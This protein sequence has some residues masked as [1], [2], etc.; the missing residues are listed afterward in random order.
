MCSPGVI[1]P[2]DLQAVSERRILS[3]RERSLD[4]AL[5]GTASVRLVACYRES[6]LRI[7]FSDAKVTFHFHWT[8]RG[9]PSKDEFSSHLA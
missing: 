7:C 2:L 4:L 6:E 8:G 1:G 5:E 3:S 9:A